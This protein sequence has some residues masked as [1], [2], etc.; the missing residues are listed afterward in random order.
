[1]RIE[2]VI[3]NNCF[4][5]SSEQNHNTN[6]SMQVVTLSCLPYSNKIQGN[7]QKLVS[8]TFSNLISQILA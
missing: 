5:S 3:T 2:S 1:M 7:G 4:F 6:R 8:T